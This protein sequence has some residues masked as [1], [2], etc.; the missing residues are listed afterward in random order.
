MKHRAQHS[1]I[2]RGDLKYSFSEK[3]TLLTAVQNVLFLQPRYTT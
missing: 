2:A 3:T 1:S